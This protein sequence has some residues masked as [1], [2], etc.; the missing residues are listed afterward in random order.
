[1]P[2]WLRAALLDLTVGRVTRA[3]SPLGLGPARALLRGVG[4][5]GTVSPLVWAMAYD[6][7]IEGVWRATGAEPP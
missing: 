3:A 4:M 5:G 6:P 1:M 7:A 2:S